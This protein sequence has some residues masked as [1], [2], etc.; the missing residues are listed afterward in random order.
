MAQ[1]FGRDYS[2]QDLLRRVGDIAQLARVKPYR[3]VEGV[4]DGV[5]AV[6]VVTGSGFDFTVLPGRGMDISA[7]GYN[8]RSLAWRSA[9]GQTHPAYFDHEGENGRGWLRSFYGGLVVTCGLSYA[10]ANG[11]DGEQLY[12]LHG[13]VS[14]LPAYGVSWSGRWAGDE[15]ELSV[16]GTVRE[17]TVF[18]EY[19]ELR[20]QISTRLGSRSL[21][22][23]DEVENLGGKASDHMILYHINLGFPVVDDGAVLLAPTLSA[24]PRDNDARDGAESYAHL[25][26]PENGYREKV[27]FHT[28]APSPEGSVTCA[29]AN[30][31]AANGCGDSQG[32]G[33]YC[34]YSPAELPRFTEWK[35]MDSGTY[36]LGMEPANCS[37]MGRAKERE[38][39]TLARLQP[40]ETRTYRLEIGVLSG[41]AE[42][43]E[44]E[45]ECRAAVSAAGGRPG[46]V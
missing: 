10:G 42:I 39:G 27:Y 17:A 3:L 41:P 30:R 23:E 16:S 28:L 19:L 22:I 13:R 5:L 4:E 43:D 46:A 2:R 36:V 40:G 15:Y 29:V 21:T 1:L 24:T 32:L 6:D 37:V 26:A 33:V 18:G 9:T 35:M 8:G 14:N 38:S 7:A 34:R 25:Q 44:V 45:R 12:G 31:A 20:R 11:R